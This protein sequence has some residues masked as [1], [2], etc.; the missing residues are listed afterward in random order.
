MICIIGP[1]GSGKSTILK[2]ISGIITPSLGSITLDDAIYENGIPKEVRKKFGIVFQNNNLL[3]WR[4]V[5]KNLNLSLELQKL[6]GDEW[7]HRIEETLK[8]VGLS[9]YIDAYPDELS[10]GMKQRVNVARALVHNPE[11]LLMDQ[12]FGALDAITR[13]IISLEFLNLWKETKKTVIFITNDIDEA[14]LLGSEV[15]I[16]SKAPGK[17]LEKIELDR[18]PPET[19]NKEIYRN[20]EFL[21]YRAMIKEHMKKEG[22]II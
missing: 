20:P 15:Y 8:M 17:I 6:K 4:T 14:L 5:G 2:M 3:S 21:K 10:G 9:A 1:S 16:L 18:L 13:R 22:G 11:I 12:P 7:N 19:R